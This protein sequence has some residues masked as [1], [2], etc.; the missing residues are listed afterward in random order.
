MHDD[1]D[2]PKFTVFVIDDDA[3]LLRLLHKCLTRS[4][5]YAFSAASGNEAADWLKSHHADLILLDLHLPD[6]SREEM[7]NRLMQQHAHT[8]FII[9][10]GHG[11]ERIAVEMMKKGALDYIVK[12]GN[13]LEY[14][15]TVIE[16]S[17]KQIQNEKRH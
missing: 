17:L 9:I 10:T 1:Q 3:G 12:D 11:D 5:Y 4:G 8:P 16:R 7:L 2:S 15:P 14:V 6:V 13:F